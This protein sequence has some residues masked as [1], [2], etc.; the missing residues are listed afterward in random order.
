MA[1]SNIFYFHPYLG[2]IPILTNIFQVGWNH[3]LL[4]LPCKHG[5][6]HKTYETHVENI[7]NF[8]FGNII[9]GSGIASPIIF[10]RP[11]ASISRSTTY[12]SNPICKTFWHFWHEKPWIQARNWTKNPDFIRGNFGSFKSWNW[13]RHSDL[14]CNNK[15]ILDCELTIQC[16][17][18][19]ESLTKNWRS[20]SLFHPVAIYQSRSHMV[21]WSE[22]KRKVE[23]SFVRLLWRRW[24]HQSCASVVVF[25][26]FFSSP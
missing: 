3:Q 10:K 13:D 16:I 6:T 18:C 19:F 4:T 14:P 5:E 21:R 17:G 1:V 22:V 23:S 20:C 25:F 24:W 12:K 8:P 7:R 11:A 15:H 26:V 2:K 9:F